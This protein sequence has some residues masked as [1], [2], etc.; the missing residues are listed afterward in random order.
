MRCWSLAGGQRQS[1]LTNHSGGGVGN[2]MS[3][4]TGI[5]GLDLPFLATVE[6]RWSGQ[7]RR[8]EEEADEA[9]LH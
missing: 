1:G 8:G 7:T 4:H 6:T 3:C 9:W 2:T 5:V